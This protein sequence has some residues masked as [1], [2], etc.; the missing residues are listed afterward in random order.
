MDEEKLNKILCKFELLYQINSSSP[1]FITL[2]YKKIL[3][4]KIDEAQS[5]I[6][7]GLAHFPEHPTA[8]LL[9]SKIL[10]KKGNFT[11]ALKLIKR[12]SSIIGNSKTFDY[13]LSE[14]ELLNKQTSSIEKV[15][16]I[17][18][19]SHLS[20]EIRPLLDTEKD[21]K[22]K[23]DNIGKTEVP[24]SEY[25]AIDD[26]LIISDTLAKIYFNQKEYKEAIRIY[27]KLKI[28]HPEKSQFYD[29]K[30]SEIKALLENNS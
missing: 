27:E 10:V 17:K 22:V 30:I 19:L 11:Q 9:K 13:Y 4:E 5:I 15:E 18:P 16:D 25:K 12:A 6:D 20:D 1:L 3:D 14:L 29:S 28:K 8:L 23:D 7:N 24:K 21:I 26:T 2:A